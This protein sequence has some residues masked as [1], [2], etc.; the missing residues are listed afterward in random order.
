MIRLLLFITLFL[1]VFANSQVR[2]VCI[3][4]ASASGLSSAVFLKDKG[5]DPLVI[6][7]QPQ[8]GGH[9]NTFYFTAPSPLDPN[10]IDIGVQ[11]YVNTTFLNESGLG[12]WNL[13]SSNFANRFTGGRAFP[14]DFTKSGP[15]YAA[16]LKH[17]I[18]YGLQNTAATPEFL[19]AFETLYYIVLQYPWLNTGDYPDPI[20]SELLVPFS[21]F[22]VA[23]NLQPLNDV[24]FRE[25][26]F[27]GGMG[28]YQYLQTIYALQYL[29][30]ASL[31][32]ITTPNVTFS[33]IGGNILIYE[34]IVNY[35]GAE[36]VLLNTETTLAL[37]PPTGSDLPIVLFLKQGY[38]YQ[39]Q[40][41]QKLIVA[42]PPILEDI[43]FLVPTF[44][45]FELFRYAVPRYYFTAEVSVEGG[46][47]NAGAYSLINVD[48][49][50]PFNNTILPSLLGIQRGL[51]YGPAA[52]GISSDYP[53]SDTEAQAL[54]TAQ[55][56]LVPNSLATTK[57]LLNF[58]S[59]SRFQPHFTNEALLQSPTPYTRLDAL[60][61]QRNTYYLSVLRRFAVSTQ[62]WE[63]SYNL[64]QIYF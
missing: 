21:E 23:N 9:T 37:R 7:I 27:G 47:L 34:G 63:Q 64:V 4:G 5:Y 13:S 59:H 57:A 8:I 49:T 15:L 32:F 18:S 1:A 29:S 50:Q 38:N 30:P 43:D 16:D 55:L 42:F 6:E 45:E 28:S 10:W 39:I 17:N 36:N 35:L 11:V 60:Q 20:P 53:I 56:Q 62:M 58:K 25:L 52:S 2:D 51:P 19:L 14:V 22:I 54:L 44:E 40:Q 12:V 46:I 48:L 41:C 3:L 26:I 31:S 24:I 33:I 61:G